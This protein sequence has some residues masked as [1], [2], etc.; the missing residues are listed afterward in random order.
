MTLN[1]YEQAKRIK[2]NEELI[3]KLEFALSVYRT[4]TVLKWAIKSMEGLKDSDS[5]AK[6]M[7]LW[8]LLGKTLVIVRL[9]TSKGHAVAFAQGLLLQ[10]VINLYKTLEIGTAGKSGVGQWTSLKN[11]VINILLSFMPSPRNLWFSKL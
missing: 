9:M 2:N 1:L 3:S 5:R 10:P 8:Q 7:F 11:Q 4:V 6:L